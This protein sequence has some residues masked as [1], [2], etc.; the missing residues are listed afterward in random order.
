L[1]QG[2]QVLY[3]EWRAM[4]RRRS[5]LIVVSLMVISFSLTPPVQR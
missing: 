1:G 3:L 4:R 5:C 2:H